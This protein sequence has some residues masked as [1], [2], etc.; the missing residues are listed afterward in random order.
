MTTSPTCAG[1][2]GVDVEIDISADV[3]SAVAALL[4]NQFPYSMLQSPVAMENLYEQKMELYEEDSSKGRL[5]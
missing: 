2:R 5:C 4:R 1:S 3:S